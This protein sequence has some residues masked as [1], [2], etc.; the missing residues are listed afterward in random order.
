MDDRIKLL[1]KK[2]QEGRAT[3]QEREIIEQ[4]FQLHE[5]IPL[6]L[7]AH[8]KHLIYKDLDQRMHQFS[9]RNLPQKFK[10]S[11][12]LPYAALLLICLSIGLIF[13][14]K[15]IK[16]SPNE[17]QYRKFTTAYGV[18]KQI[19]LQDSSIVYLNAGSEL[20]IPDNFGKQDRIVQ[21]SGEAFF[22]IKKDPSKQF[23]IST[24][25]SKT[26]VLGTSF[27]IKSYNEDIKEK[28]TVS[29]GKIQVSSTPTK[30]Y[31]EAV[32]TQLSKNQQLSFSKSGN[33]TF[34]VTQ[35]NAS[36]TGSWRY[37]QLEFDNASIQ[38]ISLMLSRW[39]GISVRLLDP[40]KSC[41]KYTL[42]F[43]N[44]PI[45]RVLSVLKELSGINYTINKN[46]IIIIDSKS[47]KIP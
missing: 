35:V 22:E 47:C 37:D 14:K 46:N 39:Y 19:I 4:W 41:R 15:E 24:D 21:L 33:P 23:I 26:R 34:N 25:H 6:A 3:D 38:E 30:I 36:R 18:R 8:E 40:S 29:E 28:I 42:S 44:E 13:F 5:Q 17:I 11:Y 45:N 1:F 20:T 31:K 43:N 2:Y 10:I 16:T 27:N 32:T 9:R 12:I 7:D